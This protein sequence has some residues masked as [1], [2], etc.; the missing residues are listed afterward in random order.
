LP[1]RRRRENREPI[2]LT[3]IQQLGDIVFGLD[4][5][6]NVTASS[7]IPPPAKIIVSQPKSKKPK[8]RAGLKITNTHMKSLVSV[9]VVMCEV[10]CTTA[11]SFAASHVEA[12]V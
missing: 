6:V 9:T 8:K 11:L 3:P 10:L 1:G 4:P 5:Q 2:K 7:A 12:D